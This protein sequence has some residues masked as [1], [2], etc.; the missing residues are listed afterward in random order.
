MS[1]KGP[2]IPA[3]PLPKGQPSKPP[4]GDESD[5]SFY[6]K[7]REDEQGSDTS[8]RVA[9]RVDHDETHSWKNDCVSSG[10]NLQYRMSVLEQAVRDGCRYVPRKLPSKKR[11]RK[12]PLDCGHH[13]LRTKILQA[14]ESQM[15]ITQLEMDR[16][17]AI[18]N[19]QSRM[20]KRLHEVSEKRS[21]ILLESQS[22]NHS[23]ET[24]KL[25]NGAGFGKGHWLVALEQYL[26]IA[27]TIMPLDREPLA[28]LID[29]RCTESTT[30]L[31]FTLEFSFA[32]NRFFSDKVLRKQY[33]FRVSVNSEVCPKWRSDLQPKSCIGCSVHWLGTNK[34]QETLKNPKLSFFNFFDPVITNWDNIDKTDPKLKRSLSKISEL[35]F[36]LGCLIRTKVIPSFAMSPIDLE[37]YD[38]T[39]WTGD[40]LHPC[41]K[42]MLY[43]DTFL[44][45][46][47]EVER[48]REHYT[49]KFP[50]PKNFSTPETVDEPPKTKKISTKSD[51]E[52]A[53][54][55]REA[56][57][58][59]DY[60][61]R[62]GR[63]YR[64]GDVTTSGDSSSESEENNDQENN[65]VVREK[66]FRGLLET[67]TVPQHRNH[68]GV[69]L[70]ELRKVAEESG[71]DK[72]EI[73]SLQDLQSESEF[74]DSDDSNCVE[75]APKFKKGIFTVNVNARKKFRGTRKR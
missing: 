52:A 63:A 42:A 30:F 13:S 68:R 11:W 16:N 66:S 51:T 4:P 54:Q 26:P 29:I 46:A 49:K 32:K 67:N 8:P 73:V 71:E 48:V 35:D 64:R 5:E 2:P 69:R 31:S 34:S 12:R 7:A 28:F 33:F 55:V 17:V 40:T 15:A 72:D 65:E 47:E 74:T 53:V 37:P 39:L 44:C 21:R 75:E 60:R 57:K 41:E 27:L 6:S 24:A 1:R 43:D 50:A 61:I 58:R 3:I 38:E 18:F 62:H 14:Y 9:R 22:A 10:E 59:L 25:E 20:L 19:E 56:L 23:D 70:K 36:Y 45:T